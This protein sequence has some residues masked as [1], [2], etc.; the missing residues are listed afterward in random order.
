MKQ[1][2]IKLN[3]QVAVKTMNT[4]SPFS[5]K[6]KSGIKLIS[7]KTAERLTIEWYLIR[8]DSGMTSSMYM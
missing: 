8:F 5:M 3:N 7:K 1:I 4:K 6:M 2:Q